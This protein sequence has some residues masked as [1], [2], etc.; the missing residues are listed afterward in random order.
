MRRISKIRELGPSFLLALGALHAACS[1]KVTSGGTAGA[2]NDASG[3]APALRGG[4]ANQSGGVRSAQGGSRNSES[5]GASTTASEGGRAD[6]SR[7]GRSS[8]GRGGVGGANND[9]TRG[10][11]SA[12]G[13]SSSSGGAGGTIR[14]A[15][16]GT[17]CVNDSACG[18][19]LWC[20]DQPD[21]PQ[22]FCTADCTR[23][24]DC[25]RLS[26]GSVCALDQMEGFCLQG[27]SVGSGSVTKCQQRDDFTCRLFAVDPGTV[28]RGDADC[29]AIGPAYFCSSNTCIATACLPT[30]AN[31]AECG[32]GYC[33]LGSGYCADTKPVGLPLGSACD[34]SAAPDPCAGTCIG[35]TAGTFSLCSGYCNLGLATSCGWD[36]TGKADAAC[37]F[38]PAFN[39]SPGAGDAGFCAQLCDCNSDC[40][41]PTFTCVALDTP[42][43][44]V[45]KRAGYCTLAASTD[46]VIS[47]CPGAGAGGAGGSGGA[48][49]G[50]GGSAGASS[51]SGGVGATSGLGG[52]GGVGGS[53]GS[54]GSGGTS[55]VGGGSSGSSG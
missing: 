1:G 9:S 52:G 53:S 24:S 30:C 13:G 38:A 11:R 54:S 41:N 50:S 23:N 3:G 26:P 51:A 19:N 34:V 27:C 10:G 20:Y 36:G 2:S 15:N 33:D 5:G 47:K 35:D 55:G 21:V 45:L 12:S 14:N 8:V 44:R 49:S 25:E 46:T 32:T 43:A 42:E 16:L 4:A 6:G 48:G 22:G 28:C 40:Q 7:G 31:D 17:A 18:A 37:L 29:A 39:D